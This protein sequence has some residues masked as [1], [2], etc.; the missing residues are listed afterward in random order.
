M[1]G[2]ISASLREP[3]QTALNIQLGSA[4][5]YRG[6]GLETRLNDQT[7]IAGSFK[8]AN[9]SRAADNE[10]LNT[11]F[12]QSALYV[13]NTQTVDELLIS[14]EVIAGVG[15]D[16]GKSSDR[17]PAARIS[18]YPHDEHLIINLRATNQRGLFAQA[19]VHDQDWA[20]RTERIGDRQNVSR[21]QSQT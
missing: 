17:F 21:Y 1:G 15:H 12:Q 19:Y 7:T 18:T 10:Q 20:S 16:L 4:G 14:S 3:E 9:N 11:A 2:V 8:S 5:T 6:F 13:R